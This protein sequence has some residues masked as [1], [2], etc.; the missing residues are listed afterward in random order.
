[1]ESTAQTVE[2]TASSTINFTDG[3]LG[4]AIGNAQ[5]EAT[6]I[7]SR[8]IADLLSPQPGVLY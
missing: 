4:N 5:I 7:A 1:V 8:N 3:G 2:V 6:L